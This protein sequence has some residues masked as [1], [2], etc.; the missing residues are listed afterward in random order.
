[1]VKF[2]KGLGCDYFEIKNHKFFKGIKFHSLNYNEIPFKNNLK[3]KTFLKD[4]KCTDIEKELR[5]SLENNIH[6]QNKLLKQG[7][8]CKKSPWFHYNTRKVLI[9]SDKLQYI[10]P[11]KNIIKGEVP[12]TRECKV[13]AV[14]DLRFE[15]HTPKRI[16][17]FKVIIIIKLESK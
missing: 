15:L 17:F 16:F 9:Y 11:T 5:I 4:N 12:L 6:N 3:L 8:L 2:S 7:I 14:N 13:V 1:M 10:D